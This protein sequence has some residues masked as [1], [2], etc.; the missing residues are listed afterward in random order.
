MRKII[1]L[2]FLLSQGAFAQKVKSASDCENFGIG[3]NFYNSQYLNVVLEYVKKDISV[4]SMMGNFEKSIAILSNVLEDHKTSQD[5]IKLII[6]NIR[7]VS[8]LA[9]DDL[10][11]L[12]YIP[13]KNI[14]HIVIFVTEKKTVK[15]FSINHIIEKNL[16]EKEAKEILDNLLIKTINTGNLIKFLEEQFCIYQRSG[17]IDEKYS[18]VYEFLKEYLK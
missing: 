14:N 5:K 13:P 6:R 16:G 11:E 17:F 1:V 7:E 18:D 15:S 12:S 8:L 9:T 10:I 3:A 2:L 4:V